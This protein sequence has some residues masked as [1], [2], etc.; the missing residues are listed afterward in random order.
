M[1]TLSQIYQ[2]VTEHYSSISRVDSDGLY[3][4]GAL[5]NFFRDDTRLIDDFWKYIEHSLKEYTQTHIFKAALSCI[6]DFATY[7]GMSLGDRICKLIVD[8]L[9]H[10]QRP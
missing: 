6:C 7:Y 9:T 4:V 2:L 3:V 1:E 5:A 10:L 8:L